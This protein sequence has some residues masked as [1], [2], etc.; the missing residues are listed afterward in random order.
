MND[1]RPT[2]TADIFSAARWFDGLWNSAARA[3]SPSS[4]EWQC[5]TYGS[6][7][8]RA[9]WEDTVI[10]DVVVAL[11]NLP[12]ESNWRG[13]DEL[14]VTV[15]LDL[16]PAI[17]AVINGIGEDEPSSWPWRD[18]DVEEDREAQIA[19]A[20]D[21]LGIRPEGLAGNVELLRLLRIDD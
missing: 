10:F 18:E 1:I 5:A 20:A 9:Y 6:G 19:L 8:G 16:A 2:D 3:V 21:A 7:E 14:V 4:L 13:R 11:F 12:I 15:P 17:M